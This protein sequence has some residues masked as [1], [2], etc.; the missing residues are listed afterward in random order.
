MNTCNRRDFLKGIA[1]TGM[2]SALPA[3]LGASGP[4]IT[5]GAADALIVIWLPGGIAQTD[6]WDPKQYTPFGAGMK[7]S[8]LLG[9]CPSIAA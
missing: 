6:T 5:T 4:Q 3:S 7:G 2:A 1:A 9:T 8:E